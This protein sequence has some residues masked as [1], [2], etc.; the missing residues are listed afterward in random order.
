MCYNDLWVI[1]WGKPS[2]P[3]AIPAVVI[4]IMIIHWSAAHE[5]Q[6]FNLIILATIR[7]FYSVTDKLHR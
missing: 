5:K 6:F 2:G 7:I 4:L 3:K 1:G